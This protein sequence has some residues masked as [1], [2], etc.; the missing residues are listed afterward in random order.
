MRRHNGD[1]CR[2]VSAYA[3]W[4][5]GHQGNSPE[6]GTRRMFVSSILGQGAPMTTRSEF[7]AR[8]ALCRKLS[9]R[10]PAN[11]RLWMAEAEHWSRL[12][13][14]RLRG[15]AGESPIRERTYTLRQAPSQNSASVGQASCK[16]RCM[17]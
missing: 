1:A 6:N 8:V 17:T 10:E 14:E 9:K 13:N 12:A 15:E 4:Y 11:Q 5:I 2:C 3:R 16:V 7:S